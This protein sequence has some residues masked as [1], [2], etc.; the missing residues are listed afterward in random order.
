MSVFIA[1]TEGLLTLP[2]VLLCTTRAASQPIRQNISGKEGPP[3]PPPEGGSLDT[4]TH[5]FFFP[6]RSVQA[7]AG[8]LIAPRA[9]SKPAS[10]AFRPECN[11]PARTTPASRTHHPL[12]QR[13][14]ADG[15]RRGADPAGPWHHQRTNTG[16]AAS[17]KPI[18]SSSHTMRQSANRHKTYTPRPPRRCGGLLLVSPMTTRDSGAQQPTTQKPDRDTSIPSNKALGRY[19]NYQSP[20]QLHQWVA[21]PRG[22]PPRLR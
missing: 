8:Q 3:L 1:S 16:G 6:P 5:I 10:L 17:R 15:G 2:R 13:A 21:S 20:G 19:D 9:L 12:H 7:A 22:P 4:K 11:P 14:R 18:T